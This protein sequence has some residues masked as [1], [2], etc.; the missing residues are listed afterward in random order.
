MPAISCWLDRKATQRGERSNKKK[1]KMVSPLQWR[2]VASALR[3]LAPCTGSCSCAHLTCDKINIFMTMFHALFA[4]LQRC[5]LRS[6]NTI[7]LIQFGTLL[8]LTRCCRSS[9]WLNNLL[10]KC[11]WFLTVAWR[12][13]LERIIGNFAVY[14]YWLLTLFGNRDQSE[15]FDLSGFTFRDFHFV[16]SSLVP[17]TVTAAC[18]QL[19]ICIAF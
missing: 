12:R 6:P 3:S 5:R 2:L 9:K 4:A 16:D 8:F 11:W 15:W 18:R 17:G 19:R 14:R 7:W 1:R 10:L 13:L